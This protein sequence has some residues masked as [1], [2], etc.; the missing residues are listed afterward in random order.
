MH[1]SQ[2]H[3]EI[4]SEQDLCLMQTKTGLWNFIGTM[5]I[6]MNYGLGVNAEF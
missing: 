6:N 1:L 5:E 3:R 2:V 4:C